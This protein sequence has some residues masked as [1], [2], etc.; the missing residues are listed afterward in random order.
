MSD[1][2]TQVVEE[3]WKETIM[4]GRESNEERNWLIVQKFT[5]A[6][7]VQEGDGNERQGSL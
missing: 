2:H 4:T 7:K 3:D 1:F 5:R 6:G